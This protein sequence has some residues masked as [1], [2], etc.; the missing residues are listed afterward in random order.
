MRTYMTL[1]VGCF[2]DIRTGH[3]LIWACT[4]THTH[5]CTFPYSQLP[6]C[7]GGS[8]YREGNP[9]LYLVLLVCSPPPLPLLPILPSLQACVMSLSPDSRHVNEDVMRLTDMQL[10]WFP[11]LPCDD[12]SIK[13][14]GA[15]K[16]FRVRERHDLSRSFRRQGRNSGG[17]MGHSPRLPGE[18]NITHEHPIYGFLLT[19]EACLFG[20]KLWDHM[21]YRQLIFC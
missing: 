9:W 3:T 10:I 5:A 21:C 14:H 18:L 2:S 4:H 16:Q 7:G 6:L 12:A 1:H 15:H 8:P 13:G 11:S 19:S 17:T 20:L